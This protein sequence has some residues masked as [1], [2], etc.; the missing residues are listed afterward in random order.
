M[1]LLA[2]GL[3]R[4][5]GRAFAPLY[6]D[7]TLHKAT[8]ARTA[9][10]G[11]TVGHTDHAAKAMLDDWTARYRAEVGI[12]ATDIRIL[13]L[14]DCLTVAPTQDDEITVAGTRYRIAGP[15]RTD[16]GTTHWDIQARRDAT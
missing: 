3:K 8:L 1:A 2:L 14:Q 16:P 11:M 12:P 10:G 15:V 6:L 5:F 7:A 9:S 13:V 4:L